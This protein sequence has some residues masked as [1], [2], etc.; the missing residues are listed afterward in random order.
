LFHWSWLFLKYSSRFFFFFFLFCSTGAWTRSTH[1]ATLSAPFLWW[2]FKDRV[3]WTICLGWLQTA[4]LLISAS[5]VAGI[6]GMSCRHTAEI[7]SIFMPTSLDCNTPL[8]DSHGCICEPLVEPRVE[9]WGSHKFCPGWPEK[10]LLL[11]LAPR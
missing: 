4:I 5:W 3:S 6:T 10:A 2:V 9:R 1:W 7:L 11:S 8:C